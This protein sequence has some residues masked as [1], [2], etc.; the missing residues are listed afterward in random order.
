VTWT[1]EAGHTIQAGAWNATVTTAGTSVS[2]VNLSGNGVIASKANTTFG[3]NSTYT[4]SNSTNL[5]L[6]CSAT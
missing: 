1:W 6:T 5:T 2:A 3:F 4:G